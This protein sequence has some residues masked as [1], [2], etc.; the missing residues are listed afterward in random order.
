MHTCAQQKWVLLTWEL[1]RR[2]R[3]RR[4]FYIQ[5]KN[6]LSGLERGSWIRIG[7]SVYLVKEKYSRSFIEL[8]KRFEGPDLK[9]FK[10]KLMHTC[11]KAEAERHVCA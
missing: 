1:R 5:L 10:F 7:G 3:S 8:L 11:V 2:A 6:L 9:W 4:W